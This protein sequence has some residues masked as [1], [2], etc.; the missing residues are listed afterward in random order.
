MWAFR[1]VLFQAD[2]TF[3][4]FS[5]TQTLSLLFTCQFF[6][7]LFRCCF[8]SND[9][10][11]WKL[12]NQTLGWIWCKHWHSVAINKI[13][14]R[15]KGNQCLVSICSKIHAWDSALLQVVISLRFSSYWHISSYQLYEKKEKQ[16]TKQNNKTIAKTWLRCWTI[17][18]QFKNREF[19]K[20][21]RFTDRV[22]LLKEKEIF[23]HTGAISLDQ[24]EGRSHMCNVCF[25]RSLVAM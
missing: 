9:L 11:G 6:A 20:N 14:T 22:S 4:H 24:N 10:L 19:L 3:K 18:N 2:L 1:N 23:E 16:K 12:K 8:Q 13:E 5:L 7:V 17:A 25:P 21:P 15:I